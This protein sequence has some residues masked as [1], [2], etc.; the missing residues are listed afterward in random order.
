MSLFFLSSSS[1][2]PLLKSL[3]LSS[4][5]PLP[6]PSPSLTKHPPS[7]WL[8]RLKKRKVSRRPLVR[9]FFLAFFSSLLDSSTLFAFLLL[10][11]AAASAC[12]SSL[13]PPATTTNHLSLSLLFL[14]LLPI[15]YFLSSA[16]SASPAF[17][18]SAL[19]LLSCQQ[20]LS[21]ANSAVPVTAAACS[22]QARGLAS[23]CLLSTLCCRCLYRCCSS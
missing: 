2:L 9:P 8:L 6:S 7:H 1:L 18:Y 22:Q 11:F 3:L 20:V 17:F 10:A 5:S 13:R 14:T 4:S 12:H 19:L 16:Y 21:L 23:R 15:L